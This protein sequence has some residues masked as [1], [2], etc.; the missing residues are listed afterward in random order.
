MSIQPKII[1][2]GPVN[3]A[4]YLHK[5]SMS[6]NTIPA[7]W[8]EISADGR[9][10]KLHSGEWVAHHAD[11]GI[12]FMVDDDNMD[13]VIGLEV[14]AGAEVSPEFHK[15]VIPQCDY[16]VFSAGNTHDAD[17]S[18]NIQKTWGEAFAWL[19]TSEY[20]MCHCGVS[21]ELYVCECTDDAE[22]DNC[23]EGKLPCDIYIA[24]EKK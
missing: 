6:N 2:Y 20:K 5:T 15:A 11:Y 16:A 13:Y 24:I 8:G 17:F 3:V 9:H 14:K 4:G 7:F 19:E 1:N 18:Q 23:K 22:C 12:C 21:F 10:K